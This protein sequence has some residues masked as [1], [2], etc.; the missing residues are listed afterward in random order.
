MELA[1]AAIPDVDLGQS[2]LR[3]DVVASIAALSGLALVVVAGWVVADLVAARRANDGPLAAPGRSESRGAHREP[4]HSTEACEAARPWLAPVQAW[5]VGE[6]QPA[7][8]A[9]VATRII[10]TV[11]NAHRTAPITCHRRTTRFT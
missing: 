8:I 7:R 11:R 6:L 3:A 1:L 4:E 2:V 10:I 5:R 9:T